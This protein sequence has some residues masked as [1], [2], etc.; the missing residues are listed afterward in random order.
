M[1]KKILLFVV[2]IVGYIICWLIYLTCKKK[3]IVSN[4]IPSEPS[5]IAFWHG[6]L[7]MQPF[8]YNHIRKNH[9]ITVMIS[10]HTDGEIISRLISFFG[11]ESS[12]GSARKNGAKALLSSIR[13]MEDGYDVGITPDGP[14]G[15]RH[16]VAEGIVAIAK[17]KKAKII[18]FNFQASSFWQFDSWDKFVVPKPFSTI[19][20]F[21]GEPICIDDIDNEHSIL[22]IR[23]EMLKNAIL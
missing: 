5:I 2:P 21:A 16:S 10:E 12:R 15:P 8:L 18:P 1:K 22:L 20:F 23:N 13:K 19:T 11:F 14:K 4:N 17:K 9:K 7:L 6:E 3:F